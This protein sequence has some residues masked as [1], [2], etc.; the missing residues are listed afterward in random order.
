[1]E[2]VP[3]RCELAAMALGDAHGHA[4][5]WQYRMVMCMLQKRVEYQLGGG[6][7]GGGVK[8]KKGIAC[9]LLSGTWRLISSQLEQGTSA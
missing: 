2:T 8:G 6:G 3:G 4:G 7:G 1:M 9:L 5:T